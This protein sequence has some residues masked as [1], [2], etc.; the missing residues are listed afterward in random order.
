MSEFICGEVAV[1]YECHQLSNLVTS[2]RTHTH[3]HIRTLHGVTNASALL[4][5]AHLTDEQQQQQQKSR[6]LVRSACVYMGLGLAT[7]AAAASLRSPLSPL[8]L[9]RALNTVSCVLVT[10]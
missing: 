3:T 9:A 6:I 5:A 1:N 2:A 8:C 10:A 7:A 4:L